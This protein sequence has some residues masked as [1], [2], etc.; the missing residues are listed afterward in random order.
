MPE[1][2]VWNNRGFETIAGIKNHSKPI[3]WSTMQ[4]TKCFLQDRYNFENFKKSPAI[5]L[6]GTPYWPPAIKKSN[7]LHASAKSL[8]RKKK[9][10]KTH[11]KHGYSIQTLGFPKTSN[12]NILKT[13]NQSS[14]ESIPLS[15]LCSTIHISKPSLIPKIALTPL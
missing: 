10:R 11:R 3:S 15:I 9:S 8:I 4:W 5:T 7:H 12:Q 2:E 14:C 1:I 13:K 6:V